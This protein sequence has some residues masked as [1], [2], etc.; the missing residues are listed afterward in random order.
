[1]LLMIFVNDLWTL[2]DVPQWLGHADAQEDRLGFS[3]IIF[4]AFLFIVGLSV[5]IAI[6]NRLKK[7]YTRLSIQQHILWRGFALLVMGFFHYNLENYSDEALLPKGVWEILLTI[8]FFLVWLDYSEWKEK[9]ALVL[10][11]AGV[12]LLVGTAIVYKGQY[13]DGL[14]MQTGW[15]G[16]LGLIGWTYAV[17]SSVYLWSR[18]DLRI[19]YA[20]FGVFLLFNCAGVLSISGFLSMAMAGIITTICYR[21]NGVNSRSFWTFVV[22]SSVVLIAFGFLTRPVWDISK[23]RATPPWTAICTGISIATFAI[24]VFITDIKGI[25]KWYQW[26]KPAGVVTLTCYLLPYI[27]GGL[28]QLVDIRLPLFLR[29]GSV[30]LIKSLIFACLIIA[31]AGWLKKKKVALK[32]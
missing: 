13:E 24:I 26:I 8:A 16:I 31:V 5:P 10:K 18:G 17:V 23:I 30:G 29:T 21:R 1:M 15:W 19:Q 22:I 4:P 12:L 11:V 7:G 14:W 2:N 20:A 28:F 32:V 27:H 25:V 3:D 6:D 9:T